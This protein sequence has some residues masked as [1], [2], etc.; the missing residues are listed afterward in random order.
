MSNYTI[1]ESP[2][3]NWKDFQLPFCRTIFPTLIAQEL[4][5]V[6]PM[7][8]PTGLVF[9]LKFQYGTPKVLKRGQERKYRW[10]KKESK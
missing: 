8:A 1:I 2:T 3:W 4:M 10:L 6:Q 7:S 5:E 9:Y